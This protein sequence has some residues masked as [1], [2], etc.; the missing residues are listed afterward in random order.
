MIQP[1]CLKDPW[2]KPSCHNFDFIQH[3]K[4]GAFRTANEAVERNKIY[5]RAT[6]LVASLV[7]SPL[8]C[9]L[10][11]SFISTGSCDCYDTSSQYSSSSCATISTMNIIIWCPCALC[12]ELSIAPHHAASIKVKSSCT[13]LRIGFPDSICTQTVHLCF[14]REK[15]KYRALGD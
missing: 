7:W 1:R 12:Q 10:V 6:L 5:N 2:Y 3:S 9:N 15:T 8:S 11:K 4:L 13:I 14:Q